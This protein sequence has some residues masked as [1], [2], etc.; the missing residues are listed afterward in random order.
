MN[1]RT[2]T[3]AV[4]RQGTVQNFYFFA[5]LLFSG[6][7]EA[8]SVTE[9]IT[10][11]GGFWKSSNTAI[12]AIEPDNSHNLLAFRYNGVSYSTGVNDPLLVAQGESFLSGDF[13]ALPVSSISGSIVGNT[14]VG[15]GAL[16]DGVFNGPSNPPPVNDLPLYLTDGTKGLNLGT[17]IANLPV[18]TMTFAVNNLQIGAV[19]DGRPDILVTQIADPSATADRYEFIDVNGVRVGNYVDISYSS[20][21]SVGNW[22]VDFYEASQNPMTL[23]G[24]FT[25]TDRPIRLWAGDFSAFGINAGNVNTI[26]GFRVTLGGNSDV[27]F[28]AYNFTAIT[29]LPVRLSSFTATADQDDIKLF[30][31]T[32]FEQDF[33]QFVIEHSYNGIQFST[34]DSVKAKSNSNTIQNYSWSHNHPGNGAHF[35][36]LRLIDIDG[37]FNYSKIIRQVIKGK[38]DL[39]VQYITPRTLRISHEAFAHRK[40]LVI[41]DLNGRLML[42]Q[43]IP[44]H[45]LH[46][47]VA[48][49]GLP[50][51]VY[52]IQ[53]NTED[54][55]RG[56][57]I[58]LQ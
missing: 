24:G 1:M 6:I 29:V 57:Q 32:Q 20:I 27:A 23:V 43:V 50:P 54:K 46:S 37:H 35:Y 10:D 42:Q 31:H 14:K 13:R 56:A 12:N 5:A 40:H 16:Y 55:Q 39:L 25:Q 51:G 18:G 11:Y 9:I 34:L 53:L 22:T 48:L 44:A 8:Q 21:T 4:S 3:Q 15:L 19:G 41:W 26:T 17:G 36:R 33:M 47:I 7:A 58:I 49:H 45:S 28:V 52:R 38:Q 30:W 2:S